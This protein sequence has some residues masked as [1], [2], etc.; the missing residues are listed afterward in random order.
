MIEAKMH[1]YPFKKLDRQRQNMLL[2]L[3]E[4][5][6][7]EALDG[8]QALWLKSES[9]HLKDCTKLNRFIFRIVNFA[10]P[11]TLAFIGD[12]SGLNLTTLVKVDTR[13]N[14]FCLGARTYAC[15]FAQ[16]I[17]KE[18]G[19]FNLSFSELELSKNQ[20]FDLIQI[21]RTV[22]SEVLLEFEKNIDKYLNK[23]SFLIIENI[24]KEEERNLLWK[25]LI[26][27]ERF[28]VSLDLFD[29]GIL[30][31]REGLKKQDHNLSSSSYK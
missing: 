20:T 15:N 6:L 30:I 17:L 4:K 8:E 25:R 28:N 29:V 10:N 21:S 12:D 1:Y 7:D 14:L 11:K 9:E 18:Q 3:K 13:R 22:A 2:V 19:V 24:N 16:S 23:E 27:L 5:I 31:A 26:K